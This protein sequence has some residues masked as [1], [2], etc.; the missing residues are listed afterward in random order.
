MLISSQI[1]EFKR[2]LKI[3]RIPEQEEGNKKYLFG[4]NKKKETQ[5]KNSWLRW[6]IP[7]I[8]WLIR[9]STITGS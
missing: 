6:T 4:C 1:N 7:R 5:I 8:S 2:S 9:N 3:E